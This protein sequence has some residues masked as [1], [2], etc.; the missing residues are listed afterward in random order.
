MSEENE[1]T[2]D[3]VISEAD[4]AFVKGEAGGESLSFEDKPLEP[5][6]SRRMTAAQKCDLSLFKPG[7]IERVFEDGAYPGTLQDAILVAW[8]RLQKKSV[9]L[10][11]LRMP[12]DSVLEQATA[13]AEARDIRYGTPNHAELME[14]WGNMVAELLQAMI[15]SDDSEGEGGDDDGL[16]KSLED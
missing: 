1:S 16:G 5:F 3:D 4:L 11:A 13:W 8:L 6:C 10:K 2:I 7:N 9:V 14:L 15:E 12:V